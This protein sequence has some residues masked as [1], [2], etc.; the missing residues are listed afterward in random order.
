MLLSTSLFPVEN[1]E[2]L[3][4]NFRLLA[5]RDLVKHMAFLREELF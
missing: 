4:A 3:L 1:D 5:I 2:A